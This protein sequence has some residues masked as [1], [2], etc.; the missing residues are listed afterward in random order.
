MSKWPTKKL[1]NTIS[2]P[3]CE[4][5]DEITIWL[6]PDVEDVTH[7]SEVQQH[8]RFFAP[9]IRQIGLGLYNERRGRLNTWGGLLVR[10]LQTK[11]ETKEVQTQRRCL[12]Y[13]Y[14]WTKQQ[15][16]VS[17]FWMVFVPFLMGVWGFLIRYL[18]APLIISFQESFQL[19]ILGTLLTPSD[20]LLPMIATGFVSL[21]LLLS[22]LWDHRWDLHLGVG[23]TFRSTTLLIPFSIMMWF[24]V[25]SW[26]VPTFI[27]GFAIFVC[28]LYWLLDRIG[29][30]DTSHSMDYLPVF[31]WL[32]NNEANGWEFEKAYWD[33]H[34]YKIECKKAKELRIPRYKFMTP[35]LEVKENKRGEEDE[36]IRLQMDNPWHSV[37]PGGSVQNIFLILS[38]I[39]LLI[40]IPIALLILGSGLHTDFYNGGF[41]FVIS[42]TLVVFGFR[43]IMRASSQLTTS[44]EIQELQLPESS[45]EL[46][47][48]TEKTK[49]HLNE[50]RLS[51]L[52]NLVKTK[53]TGNRILI[54]LRSLIRGG[55]EFPPDI[56]P[57]FVVITK[58]QDPFN[59]YSHLEYYHTFRDNLDYL[60]LYINKRC[61]MTEQ[62][63]IRSLE[64]K[65]ELQREGYSMEP[66][67]QMI[68]EATQ[69]ALRDKVDAKTLA[70]DFLKG[71]DRTKRKVTIEEVEEFDEEHK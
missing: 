26:I 58:L 45:N 25:F 68:F 31:V 60:Y 38:I 56:R 55:K 9:D 61:P 34:H 65:I 48:F 14:I 66:Q 53:D 32:K 49:N 16:A 44:D 71:L 39:G 23:F 63:R 54:W 17:L 52:W 21:P 62:D 10:C 24:V 1:D 27:L 47:L 3:Y 15:S 41:L 30:T 67:V 22:G 40:F 29:F 13:I 46:N 35:N 8:L 28:G 43:T 33:R 11:A 69:R 19:D 64:S 50:K 5:K 36:R 57:R 51:Q 4:I 12:Q 37:R 59:Y 2:K 70:R 18:Y 6:A 7:D 20:S 42:C